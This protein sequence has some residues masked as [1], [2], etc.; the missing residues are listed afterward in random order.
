MDLK[1][2]PFLPVHFFYFQFPYSAKRIFIPLMLLLLVA[3]IFLVHVY[4]APDQYALTLT[5]VPDITSE[6]VGVKTYEQN[7]RTFELKLDVFIQQTAF[8]AG[9]LT[10]GQFPSLLFLVFQC[11]GWALLLATSSQIRS[12]WSYLFYFLFA[13]FFHLSG[14]SKLLVADPK[15]AAYALD[16]TLIL[17][18]IGLAYSF[19]V[20][21]IRANFA[22]RFLFI[23]APLAIILGLG[24]YMK[25]WEMGFFVQNSAF[26]YLSILCVPFI[27]FVAKEPVNLIM[28]AASNHREQRFRWPIWA[29]GLV[30]FIW[31]LA[32][33]ALFFEYTGIN[34][35]GGYQLPIRP[36]HILAISG[37][38]TVFTAQNHFHFVKTALS[39]VTVYSFLLISGGLICM[40][41]LFGVFALADYVFLQMVDRLTA[42]LFFG[43][44][45]AQIV[46]I[47][48]NHLP[49]LR[50]RIN[51][52]YLLTQGTRYRFLV[53]WFIMLVVLIFAEGQAGWKTPWLFTHSR[54]L[55]EADLALMQG[56]NKIAEKGYELAASISPSSLKANYNYAQLILENPDRLN[57]AINTYK[58]IEFYPFARLNAANLALLAGQ[59]E[60]AINF[61]SAR[62]T[63]NP[64]VLNNLALLYLLQEEPD[65]AITQFKAA[66]KA[67]L[68]LAAPYLNL[69]ELYRV[70]EKP[71]ASREFIQAAL[72]HNREHEAVLANA[73]AYQLMGVDSLDI[74]QDA[75][76]ATS[77]S[78]RYNQLLSLVKQN[79][80]G[81]NMLEIR[82]LSDDNQSPGAMLLDGLRLLEADSLEVGLSRLAYMPEVYPS[83]KSLANYAAALE[84]IRRDVPEMARIYFDRMG[85]AGD[86]MGKL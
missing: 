73:L 86:P 78:L 69:A 11:I 42:I 23:L 18:F 7:Y 28:L 71:E 27:A 4:E 53:V 10:P 62:K 54:T 68:N 9:L 65:S 32:L 55:Q 50:Q 38:V 61:L 76:Q 39:S 33:A 83:T 8:A 16:F 20:A 84:Y 56:E 64:Y 25:G 67:D 77:Y 60:Q 85:E 72:A 45:L 43:V 30:S 31:L 46:F 1:R 75:V 21:L 17:G 47:F 41:H 63:T 51:F 22:Q 29:V 2:L 44:S 13:V 35:F 6:Q 48:T 74:P 81:Q 3:G 24:V 70:Y 57:E 49:L 5:E 26:T 66:L 15:W 59:N 79:G 52:Y 80:L 58:K 14:T 19:Q 36:M 40:G 34:W 37:V 82:Q 12:K